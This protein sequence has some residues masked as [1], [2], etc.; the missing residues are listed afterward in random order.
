MITY[1]IHGKTYG[2]KEDIKKLKPTGKSFKKWWR[3]DYDFKCCFVP[4]GQNSKKLYTLIEEFC[5]KNEL[6]LELI[7]QTEDAKKG[8]KDF[9]SMDAFF[10]YFHTMGNRNIKFR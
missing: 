4:K 7:E 3:Y 2:L 9:K 5:K 10:D 1:Y 8:M 6:E